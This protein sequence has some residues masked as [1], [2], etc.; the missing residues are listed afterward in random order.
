[1]SNIIVGA[2]SFLG[3]A[4]KQKL[5]NSNEI[6]FDVS[7]RPGD[8]EFFLKSLKNLLEKENIKNLFI[9][10]GSQSS[11]DKLDTLNDLI[12]S[13]VFL[14][15]AICS[16]VSDISDNTKII[17]FGSSWQLSDQSDFSPFNLYAS[18]KQAAENMLEHFAMEGLKICS[19]RLYDTY[20]KN[21]KRS[22]IVNLIANAIKNNKKLDMSE[23]KQLIDLIHINDVVDGVMHA[24]SILGKKE[25]KSL[26]KFSLK[27]GS[28]IQVRE[29]VR[30][31]EKILSKD[32]NYLFNFGYHPYRKRERLSL[33]TNDNTPEGWSPKIDIEVGLKSLID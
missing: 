4:L 6:V 26:L 24:V 3:N 15:T 30:V 19:L 32:L 5:L 17:F 13:N 27:S 23:G 10:G 7:F 9:C 28:P 14:P 12:Q 33:P 11:S 20:G 31:Y 8:E 29:I 2:G 22:K 25:S 21:D 16:L 18:S 1:L